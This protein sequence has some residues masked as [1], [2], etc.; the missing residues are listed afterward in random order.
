MKQFNYLKFLGAL[1]C[2]LS[3]GSF[4]LEA[5]NKKGDKIFKQ[6]Q[7]A[8]AD[9]DWDLAMK[10]YDQALATDSGDA[11]YLLADQRI[12]SKAAEQYIAEG[13]ELQRLQK[14]D[15]ALV[16]FQ[17]AFLADPGSQVALQEIRSTTAMLK[18]R[19][20][21]PGKP[22][23]TPAEQ[24]RQDMERRINSLEGPPTLRPINNQIHSL[25]MNNQPAR[26]LYESVCKLAGINAL[27]DPA[28]LDAGIVAG[29]NFNL[30][31][32]DVSLEE[33][34]N[35][36]ALT[37]HTFWK[38]ISRNA[39]FVTQEGEQK[40]QEY[41]DEVVKVFYVQ[42]A[43]T[44]NEFTEI[45]NGVRTGAKLTSNVFQVASQNAIIARGTP[46]TIAI[47]EKLIH[48][49]DKP[50]P[51][52]MLD[53]IVMEVNKM[54]A[55]TIGAALLGA[56]GLN[57]P[58]NYTPR[59]GSIINTTGTGTGS[60]TGTSTG[61]TSTSS[62]VT[63]AQLG[64]LSSADFSTSLPSTIVQALMSDTT[65]HILQRPQIRA[66]D[67]GKASLKIGL[68]V[69]YV[70]GSLNSAVATPGAI[71]YATTQ[72]QQVETGTLIDLEPHVNGLSDISMHIRVEL[73]NV[74]N[75]VNI[76]GITEPEIAQQIDEA[77]IRMKDGEVSILGGLSD[78]EHTNAFA[79]LPGFT[80]IPLLNYLFGTKTR[81]EQDQEVLITI[82]P[83]II[84]S[85][86]N[87]AGDGTGVF[88]GT[89]R[90]PRVQRSVQ[91]V[92][93]SQLGNGHAAGTVGNN[94]L[95]QP[96]GTAPPP[97]YPPRTTLPTTPSVAPGS[98]R[99]VLPASPPAPDRPNPQ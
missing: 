63:L 9:R 46:D 92:P 19:S 81:T 91:P 31:L 62:Q 66:T 72:F 44:P 84:R 64:H 30:D 85:P 21:D 34:L 88:A 25:K 89:E 47:V 53:V 83:H 82:I 90:V 43:S 32:S 13:R 60:N 73:S 68:K 57:V 4:H 29:K 35:Y 87:I 22:V 67:G 37:T 98:P 16:Q 69:P 54:K 65:T 7:K 28:G 15:N 23:Y 49:L 11:G 24:A 36:V 2:L 1:L 3:A 70:S 17:R 14:P 61:G 48:D 33:A 78:K 26:M 6:A 51:E 55:S 86:E 42:N 56:N 77:V 8:E 41:Q 97:Q 12:H 18:Q 5:R 76:A 10:L 80:N 74:A 71:P 52:V 96:G 50:K 79:G 75:Q 95:P 40:R 99:V 38:P 58:L 27:F 94:P 39:I 20:A 93:V 45:F 59:N